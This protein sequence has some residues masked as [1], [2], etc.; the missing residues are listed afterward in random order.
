MVIVSVYHWN[1]TG[2]ILLAISA[3]AQASAPISPADQETITQQQKALLQQAQQQREALHNNIIL[4]PSPDVAPSTAEPI[5]HTINQIEFDGAES[6]PQSVKKNLMHPYLS[7]CLS[8][9]DIHALVRKTTNAYIERGYVTSQAGLK[10]QDLSSGTL[11]ITVNEGKVE[12]ISLDGEIP[13]SLK[14]AF[15]KIVG[16]TLNL[17]EI[18]QGMERLN[19]LPS[20]QVTIDIQPSK[21][22]GYSAVILKRTSTHLPV[23][24]SL[25]SDNSGQKSTGTG[26]INA[27][28]NL[29]NPLHL[30]DQWSLSASRNSDFHNSHQSH[31]LSA[32]VAVPYSY[33]LFSYQYTWNDSFQNIPV[34]L[35]DYHYKGDNQTHRVAIN[36]TLYRDGEQKLA[37]D[38]GLTHRRTTNLFAEKTLTVSS[39]TLSIINLGIN[40][41]TVLAGSYITLNPM[42]IYG[43]QTLGATK[44]DPRFPDAPRSQFRKFSLS[45]SYFM[46]VTDSIY[47]LSSIYS[48]TTPDNLYSSE[49]L[50]L[51]GQYS[52]R[53]FK[54]QYLTGNRGG[55]WRNELNWRVSALPVLGELALTGA[56]DTGWLQKKTGQ[57]DGGNVTG[58]ALGLSLTHRRF[59]Q[60]ITIGKP[61]IHPA[62]LKPDNWVTYWSASLTL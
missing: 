58:A 42:V 28:V 47:Y 17:R 32:S 15:P 44:D 36:R 7:H 6:L 11:I 21:Q 1:L 50:S 55:Y 57:I 25:G 27:N 33:W 52:V 39:P 61:L 16:K 43:L 5:C 38:M 9:Q 45:A 41:S 12:S 30:T 56:L 22:P 2:F 14:M 31:S 3:L 19:R 46:P 13:L 20:Q 53:G 26:Q 54:E 60:T 59:N 4:S 34:D 24:A 51:G 18:E 48:Q 10:V 8:L 29:D 40:Y 23:S 62:H 37:L 49:H 35:Q